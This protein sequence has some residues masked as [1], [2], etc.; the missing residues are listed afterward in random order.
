LVATFF[1]VYTEKIC[2]IPCDRIEPE[3]AGQRIRGLS[4]GSALLAALSK[5]RKSRPKTLVDSFLYPRYGAGFFYESM[6]EAV[7]AR[8]G[9][10]LVNHKCVRIN[11]ENGRIRSVVAEDKEGHNTEIET[12]SVVSSAPMNE[13]LMMLSPSAPPDV[14]AHASKLR[15]R[16]HIAVNLEVEGRFFPDQWLYVHAPDFKMARMADYGNFSEE[17]TGKNSLR[18]LTVEYFAFA[19]DAL[20]RTDD[21][22]IIELAKSEVQKCGM[23]DR[24]RIIDGEVIRHAS[25]YPMLERGYRDDMEPVKAH[26]C[27]LKGLQ[28]IGRGGM[29]RY[30]NQDHAIATGLLAARN[31]CGGRYD[32]W[33]VNTDGS[34][35]ESGN[36]DQGNG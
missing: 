16:G 34:Y 33:K 30:N 17:M 4:P 28:M 6:A 11:H 26:L 15:Y 1:K 36:S 3:W 2:G 12:D 20:W 19:E 9:K 18:P 8:S 27:S 7:S 5:N 13:T 25:A 24:A 31:L 14:S 21:K 32:V 23:F 10:V 29:Y 22:G 35:H